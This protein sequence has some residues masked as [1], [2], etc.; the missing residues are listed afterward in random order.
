MFAR[1]HQAGMVILSPWF[2]RNLQ[3]AVFIICNG[4]FYERRSSGIR[5]RTFFH[6]LYIQKCYL[7]L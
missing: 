4:S 3:K 7:F 1:L 2:I 5:S 6:T